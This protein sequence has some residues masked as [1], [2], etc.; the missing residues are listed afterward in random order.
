[1]DRVRRVASQI[2]PSNRLGRILRGR[3]EQCLFVAIRH[4]QFHVSHCVCLVRSRTPQTVKPAVNSLH[5]EMPAVSV[6]PFAWETRGSPSCDSCLPEAKDPPA[7][8]RAQGT[9]SL[10]T[11]CHSASYPLTSFSSRKL[12]R[13]GVVKSYRPI[14]SLQMV[15]LPG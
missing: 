13:M 6:S 4:V 2:Y 8:L 12:G 11:S 15:L 10:S 9:S 3:E 14:S 5:G 7:K 1:M